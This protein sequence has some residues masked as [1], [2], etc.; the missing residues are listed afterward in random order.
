MA[1]NRN[2]PNCGAPYEIE[3]V[4]CPYCG[5]A[6]FDMSMIDMDAQE[7]FYLKI[8]VNGMLIT[9]MV[10]P[11]ASAFTQE[12]EELSCC[13]GLGDTTLFKVNISRSLSTDLSFKAV[14][15]QRDNTLAKIEKGHGYERRNAR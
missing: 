6:Y 1:K 5:T 4:R 8:K 14:P 12:E 3:E 10:I 7:P 9:Q 2:C 11:I 15:N 13:G